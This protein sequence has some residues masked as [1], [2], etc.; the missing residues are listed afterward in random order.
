MNLTTA[1][2]DT[3]CGPWFAMMDGDV[4]VA[5]DFSEEW[6]ERA[7]TRRFRGVAPG[8]APKRHP[9]L[10][11]LRAY[12]DGE[13]DALDTIEVRGDGTEF[14]EKVW[15]ALRR[16]PPGRPVS[17][18]ALAETIGMPSAVRAVANANARNCIAVVQPCHRV[19]AADG[20]LH[21]FGGGLPMKR[22]LLEHE[23]WSD[24]ASA[25]LPGL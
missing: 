22:W 6:R 2:I 13:I 3:P 7:L 24:A 23:G 16:I 10:A 19:V 21:G 12:L 11:R 17:Y 8:A 15:K 1:R 5:L 9:V 14:Q 20:S 25:R 18:G 4:L